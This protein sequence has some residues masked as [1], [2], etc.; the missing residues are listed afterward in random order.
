MSWRRRRESLAPWTTPTSRP[1]EQAL[2]G[3]RAELGLTGRTSV[4]T[5]PASSPTTAPWKD[6]GRNA[7]LRRQ[8][9]SESGPCFPALRFRHRPGPSSLL[10]PGV[11][12]V[13]FRRQLN[14]HPRVRAPFTFLREPARWRDKKVIGDRL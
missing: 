5:F 2:C 11:V 10:Q 1:P 6:S 4:T 13:A 7:S 12:V 14:P 8:T 9:D 3:G